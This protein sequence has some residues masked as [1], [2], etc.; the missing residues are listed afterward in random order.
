MAPRG[1]P[2]DSANPNVFTNAAVAAAS[3]ASG[4][5]VVAGTVADKAITP[6]TLGAAYVAKTSIQGGTA[7]F[8]DDLTPWEVQGAN[9]Y[10]ANGMYALRLEPMSFGT[11]TPRVETV[12]KFG[13]N[14]DVLGGE[15]AAFFTIHPAAHDQSPPNGAIEVQFN[16]NYPDTHQ[17]LPLQIIAPRTNTHTSTVSINHG[18]GGGAVYINAAEASTGYI[19]CAGATAASPTTGAVTVHQA[20]VAN[21]TSVLKGTVAVGNPGVSAG[22]LTIG[23]A[24]AGSASSTLRIGCPTGAAS[25]VIWTYNA[26]DQWQWYQTSGSLLYLRDVVNGRMLMT[27]VPGA[28][29]TASRIDMLGIFRYNDAAF[30]QTTVGAAGAA[31]ALPATPTEYLKVQN[32]AGQTRVIPCYAP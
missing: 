29:S 27:C 16:I 11:P 12:L 23:S 21:T 10:D 32:N 25:A 15:P 9:N 28:S 13:Y 19:S 17:Y 5:E 7:L 14:P 30:W 26:V 2:V 24:T 31:S 4:A 6:A 1:V 22:T 18:P 8:P 20:F 3:L